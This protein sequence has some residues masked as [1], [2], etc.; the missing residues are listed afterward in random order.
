MNTVHRSAK[1][2]HYNKESVH[3]DLFNEENS[4]VINHTIESIL[5]KHQA[6]TVLDLTCGTGSQVFWLAKSGYGVIGSDINAHMLKIAKRKAKEAKLN[7]QFLK[8]DMRTAKVGKFDAVITIFNAIGHLTK[9]DFE[10]AIQNI[11]DNLNEGGLYIFDI[12]NL[13]YL[14]ADNNITRLTID[15]REIQAKTENRIIQYSTIDHEGILA[16]FTTSYQRKGNNTPKITRSA[17]TLQTYSAKQLKEMLR[18]NG[19]KIVSQSAI[20]GS[21]FYENK[22]D[23]ILTVAIC[24]HL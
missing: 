11:H 1:P 6:K 13:S 9:T 24:S 10:Q 17:Q 22:T 12:N 16:S 18:K 7:L 5:K 23:R 20:D 2:S 4:K 8:G 3:Y 15:W 19:F 21:P 14:Q